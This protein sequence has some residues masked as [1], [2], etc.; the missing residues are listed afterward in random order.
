M[1]QTYAGGGYA[2]YGY[3]DDEYADDG[4]VQSR[5]GGVLLVAISLLSA[6]LVLAGLVYATGTAARHKAGVLAGGCEPTLYFMRLPCITQPMVISKYD[7]IVNPAIKQLTADTAAYRANEGH[8]LVAA[9][10][11]LTAEIATEQT[12]DN[13]LATMAFTPQNRAR[14][15]SL[16][17]I[18]SS[19]GIQTPPSASITF[20]PK[21]TVVANA[22]IRANQALAELTAEQARSTSLTQLQALNPRVAAAGV[23][24]QTDMTLLR[25]AVAAPL[26]TN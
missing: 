25:K 14:A 12:L 8:R 13:G 15:L 1:S 23:T 19:T 3:A 9:E 5:A 18:A 26:A 20:T 6:C 16:I 2:D 21:M 11:A 7:G 4:D 17:T 24:V 22:L 10:A